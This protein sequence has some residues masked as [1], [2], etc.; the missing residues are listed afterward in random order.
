MTS[1]EKIIIRNLVELLTIMK[2]ASDDMI[3][4]NIN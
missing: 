4:D 1:Y 3:N 2:N